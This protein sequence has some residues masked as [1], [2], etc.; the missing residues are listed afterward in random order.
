MPEETILTPEVTTQE[1]PQAEAVVTPAESTEEKTLVESEIKESS[2]EKKVDAVVPEKYELKMPEGMVLDQATLDTFTPIFKE[3]GLSQEAVQKLADTYVPLI[4][5]TAEKTRQEALA[6][7][8]E[9]TDGWAAESKKMLGN[10]SKTELAYCGKAI[11]KFGNAKL[12]EALQETGLGNHP[13]MVDFMRKVGKTISEDSFVSGQSSA[14][15]D[16]LNIMYPSMK[17]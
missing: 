5:G 14:K 3:L 15:Q 16:P 11:Q 12:R 1:T 7:Y 6:S 10:D 4:Q 9:I 2:D 13:A 8:K 17:Q